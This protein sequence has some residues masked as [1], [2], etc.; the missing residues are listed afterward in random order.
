MHTEVTPHS[1]SVVSKHY[2][3]ALLALLSIA[4]KTRDVKLELSLHSL[5]CKKSRRAAGVSAL[6]LFPL[7]VA[8]ILKTV[9]RL[10]VVLNRKLSTMRRGQN[11]CPPWHQTP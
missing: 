4:P 7:A 9:R 8:S 5:F 6:L 3:R 11:A 1:L 2:D 10:G